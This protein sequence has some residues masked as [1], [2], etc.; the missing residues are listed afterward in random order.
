[1]RKLVCLVGKYKYSVHMYT[2]VRLSR[3]VRNFTYVHYLMY[4]PGIGPGGGGWVGG[5]VFHLQ[6]PCE[7]SFGGI[8]CVGGKGL[9]VVTHAPA[10]PRNDGWAG[11]RAKGRPI[12]RLHS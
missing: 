12:D 8:C 1:M 5:V 2:Y 7:F 9:K 10:R 4:V 3:L 6:F 11:G